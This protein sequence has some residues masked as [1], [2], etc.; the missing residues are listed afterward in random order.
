MEVSRRI[1]NVVWIYRNLYNFFCLIHA[2]RMLFLYLFL[3]C[4]FNFETTFSKQTFLKFSLNAGFL[5]I[6]CSKMSSRS[7]TFFF[8]LDIAKTYYGNISLKILENDVKNNE[9]FCIIAKF[10]PAIF[11]NKLLTQEQ[12]KMCMLNI[13]DYDLL[14]VI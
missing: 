5:T 13:Q 12:H 14:S 9:F 1:H 7:R 3:Y 10:P 11:W 4:M 2:I 6:N 8:L